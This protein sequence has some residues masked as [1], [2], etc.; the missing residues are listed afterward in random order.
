M[1]AIKL[2]LLKGDKFILVYHLTIVNIYILPQ[3]NS[4]LLPYDR[5]W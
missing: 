1:R 3:Q 5:I 2:H 4:N